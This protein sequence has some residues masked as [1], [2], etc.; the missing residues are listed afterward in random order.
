MLRRQPDRPPEKNIV[1]DAIDA[2]PPRDE[3]ARDFWH[4]DPEVREELGV[5]TDLARFVDSAFDG[6]F[7]SCSLKL[8]PAKSP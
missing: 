6:H 5:S 3:K 4:V 7:A 2:L 8:A 1:P